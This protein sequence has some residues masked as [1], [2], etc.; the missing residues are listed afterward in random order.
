MKNEIVNLDYNYI[1]SKIILINKRPVIIDRDVAE[2]Y[3]VETKD[4][5]RAMKNNPDKFP[6]DF[7]FE[8]DNH[9]KEEV[10]KNFHH[11]STLAFSHVPVKIF[12]EQGLYMVATII[13]NKRATEMTIQI[14][15]TFAKLREIQSNLKAGDLNKSSK[16]LTELFRDELDISN[17]NTETSMEFNLGF[18]KLK[19]KTTSLFTKKNKK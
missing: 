13:K 5:T 12:T 18:L 10:V 9:D 2:I 6:D 7:V 8:L 17:V 11:L 3:G 15:R 14:I 1:E 4:L 16:L 19:Q